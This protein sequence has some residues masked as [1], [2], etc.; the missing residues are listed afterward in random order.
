[1]PDSGIGL[2]VRIG[3]VDLKIATDKNGKMMYQ[4]RAIAGGDVSDER[5]AVHFSDEFTSWHKGGFIKENVQDGYYYLTCNADCTY[6]GRI[7]PAM[8][9]GTNISLPDP[10]ANDNVYAGIASITS[11][12]WFASGQSSIIVAAYENKNN[13]EGTVGSDRVRITEYDSAFAVTVNQTFA[14]ETDR[15]HFNYLRPVYTKKYWHIPLLEAGF[16][17]RDAALPTPWTIKGVGGAG[18]GIPVWAFGHGVDRLYRAYYPSTTSTPVVTDDQ[19]YFSSA[20][21]DADVT[22]LASWTNPGDPIP[23]VLSIHFEQVQIAMLGRLPYVGTKSGVFTFGRS[24]WAESLFPQFQESPSNSYDFKAYKNY[25]AMIL[26]GTSNGQAVLFTGG[27]AVNVGPMVNPAAQF[28]NS[29]APTFLDWAVMS[30]GRIFG[31]AIDGADIFIYEGVP[32]TP[33]ESGPGPFAWHPLLCIDAVTTP[34]PPSSTEQDILTGDNFS[35]MRP[36]AITNLAVGWPFT[37]PNTWL[38]YGAG[39]AD[40]RMFRWAL[41]NWGDLEAGQYVHED[42]ELVTGISFRSGRYNRGQKRSI[43]HWI[44]LVFDGENISAADPIRVRY[45]VDGGSFVQAGQ[46]ESNHQS[47]PIDVRG[48]DIE[49]QLDWYRNASGTYVAGTAARQTAPA[50]IKRI[51]YEGREQPQQLVSISFSVEATTPIFA[52]AVRQKD[53]GSTLFNTVDALARSLKQTFRDPF[54]NDRTVVVL[55][56]TAEDNYFAEGEMPPTPLLQVNLLEVP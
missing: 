44:Q 38:L 56:P 49:I 41:G 5:A 45:A 28:T 2:E 34:N 4:E 14:L 20:A 1:M 54:K 13:A 47:I 26:A 51:I 46:L 22:A 32:R 31:T 48:Y 30:S 8:R 40:G 21:L 43:K 37:G 17:R 16:A 9:R 7:F 6:P 33:G 3:S 36:I 10:G 50:T 12:P 15:F 35:M 39:R 27:D 52:G 25:N 24:G 11:T 23:G 55:H 18:A 53:Y 42:Q 19:L 29:N